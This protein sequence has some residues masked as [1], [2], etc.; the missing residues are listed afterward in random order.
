[1]VCLVEEVP[2]RELESLGL[3]QAT[4]DIAL[5]MKLR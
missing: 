2:L 3:G 1:M 5:G 4:W